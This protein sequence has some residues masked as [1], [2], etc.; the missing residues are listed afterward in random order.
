MSAAHASTL[1]VATLLRR[2]GIVGA[3]ALSAGISGVAIGLAARSVA[4]NRMAPWIIG[5]ASGITSYLLIVALVLLG[6]VLARTSKTGSARRTIRRIRLH[7]WLATLALAFTVL[8]IVVLATDS[9]A[10]VGWHGVLV[11]MGAT[12]RPVATTLGQVGLVSGLLAGVTAAFGGHL[13]LRLW[14]PIHKVAAVSLLLVWLHGF[15]GGSDTAALRP[16][17]LGT[18][19]LVLAVAAFRYAP[20]RERSEA[21]A[22]ERFLVGR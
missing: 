14:W 21:Q 20:V 3:G 5:R 2:L 16:L 19:G 17:Y 8:H 15:F 11:P 4:R 12:Y 10:G 22:D 13:P 9:Y 6:L 1:S 7:A 18:A